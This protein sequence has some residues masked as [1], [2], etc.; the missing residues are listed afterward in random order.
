MFIE[1]KNNLPTIN[2]KQRINKAHNL[3]Q[4]NIKMYNK[5]QQTKSS[6]P[7]LEILRQDIEKQ[8]SI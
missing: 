3:Y 6:I 2:L 1:Q 7:K 8:K 4:E 5:L